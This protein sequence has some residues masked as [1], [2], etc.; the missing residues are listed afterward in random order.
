GDAVNGVTDTLVEGIYNEARL[1]HQAGAYT[2]AVLC[3]RKLLMN[4]AVSKGAPEGKSFVEYIDYLKQNHWVPPDS[5]DW[6]DHIRTAGNEA[7]HKIAVKT[8]NDSEELIGF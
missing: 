5:D 4:L 8:A 2:G 6:V 1:A 7:T 3:C